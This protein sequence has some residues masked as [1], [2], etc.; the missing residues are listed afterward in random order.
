MSDKQKAAPKMN[1][2]LKTLNSQSKTNKKG[3]Q[4]RLNEAEKIDS[5]RYVHRV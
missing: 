2:C 4:Q 3:K 5:S 1:K